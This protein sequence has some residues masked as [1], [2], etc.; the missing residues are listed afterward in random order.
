MKMYRGDL[1]PDLVITLMDGD[2]PIDL[3]AATSVSVVGVRDGASLFD[4]AATSATSAGVVT[5]AWQAADTNTAGA[6]EIEVEVVWPGG[7]TQTFRPRS[8]VTIAPLAADAAVEAAVPGALAT[9][10]AFIADLVPDSSSATGAALSATFARH[11]DDMVSVKAHPFNAKGDGRVFHEAAVSSASAVITCASADFASS[12][13]GKRVT[14]ADAAS[15]YTLVG[16]VASVQSA[17]QLTASVAAAQAIAS[18]SVAVASDDTAAFLAAV[19]AVPMGGAL[20]VPAAIYGLTDSISLQDNRSLLGEGYEYGLVTRTIGRGSVLLAM[21]T[22]LGTKSVVTAG[23]GQQ[24]IGDVGNAASYIE[25]MAI[26]A[27]NVAAQALTILG[28]RRRVRMSQ[29]WRGHTYAL[30]NLCQNSMVTDCAIGQQRRGDALYLNAGD[31]KVNG[32]DIR[33]GGGS[34]IRALNA[35][36]LQI[37]HNHLYGAYSGTVTNAPNSPNILLE[38]TAGSHFDVNI[39]DNLLDGTNGEHVKMVLPASTFLQGFSFQGNQL[40]QN[41]GWPSATYS[42]VK[43]DLTAGSVLRAVAINGNTGIG[44]G[45]GIYTAIMEKTGAGTLGHSAMTGNAIRGCAAFWLGQRPDALGANVIAKTAASTFIALSEN[46][47]MVTF[48]G[49]GAQT[50]FTFVHNLAAAP[51]WASIT[52]GGLATA[53]AGSFHVSYDSGNINVDFLTAPV[54]GVDNVKLNWRAGL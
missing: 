40:L 24:G 12:D 50:R 34:Q 54:S 22:A 18:G 5:M 23:N 43:F 48:S 33:E 53:Q 49:T 51:S 29:F 52:P 4:R 26:D 11:S 36:D 6:I 46:G 31:I 15:T 9:L 39:N 47:G 2:A 1:K 19:A 17:S 38:Y 32:C 41:A 8:M 25:G 10:D 3:S 7:K 37:M 44:D 45:T 35:S 28:Y 14:L 42:V 30:R 16:T 13:V 20:F 21:G 27:Q